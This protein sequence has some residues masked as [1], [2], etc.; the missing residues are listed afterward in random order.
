LKR[1]EYTKA[2]R[3]A[4]NEAGPVHKK[5]RFNDLLKNFRQPG[6]SYLDKIQTEIFKEIGLDGKAIAQL[7]CN[8]GRELLSLKNLGAGKCVGFDISD[9]FIAQGHELAEAGNIN[10]DLVRADIYEISEKYTKQ[11]DIVFITI[12]AINLMPDISALFDVVSRL[13]KQDGVVFIYEMHPFIDMFSW[14]DKSDPPT[15][16]YSYFRDKPL[17]IDEM[18]NYWDMS[19]YKSSPMYWFHHKLSDVI[20]ACLENS[21]VLE[22]FREYEQDVSSTYAHFEKHSNALPLSYSMIAKKK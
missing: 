5:S 18:I 9:E 14:D 11:F 6:Y 12:G 16:E 20:S 7:C 19:T 17:I 21:L 2:N 8:N 3:L 1:E 15:I 4:W 10:C 13:L 22:M